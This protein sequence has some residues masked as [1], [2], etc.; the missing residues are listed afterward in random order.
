M[1]LLFAKIL[2]DEIVIPVEGN[3][4]FFKKIGPLQA[5]TRGSCNGMFS[6]NVADEPDLSVKL[7]GLQGVQVVM[8]SDMQLA[9]VGALLPDGSRVSGDDD[10]PAT[11]QPANQ[12]TSETTHFKSSPTAVEP[13]KT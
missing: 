7:R 1:S 6:I 8:R 12:L 10:S 5:E 4:W 3:E 9:L 2:N 13:G 11:N